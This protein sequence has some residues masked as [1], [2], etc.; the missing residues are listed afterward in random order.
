MINSINQRI[1]FYSTIKKRLKKKILNY[2][3]GVEN[4]QIKK[5]V[6]QK[7]KILLKKYQVTSFDISR[8][9]R[10]LLIFDD[11]KYKF[12]RKKFIFSLD[13]FDIIKLLYK[14]H[15]I[16]RS[17]KKTAIK[18]IDNKKPIQQEVKQKINIY[19]KT[20]K[21]ENF[22]YD[23]KT[24]SRNEARVKNA[25]FLYKNMQ[26]IQIKN[27]FKKTSFLFKQEIISEIQTRKKAIYDD[28]YIF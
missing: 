28:T 15:S 17:Q 13:V 16:T 8:K 23:L 24:Q 4:A 1:D 7:N 27:K 18:N 26:Y 19:L 3:A 12:I 6:R 21:Q 5:L 22:K 10:D 11:Y 25:Y 2:D 9:R 14:K 20:R